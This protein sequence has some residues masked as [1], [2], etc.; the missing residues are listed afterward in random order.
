MPFLQGQKLLP[1]SSRIAD[2]EARIEREIE[3]GAE[4][5]FEFENESGGMDSTVFVFEFS[6]EEVYAPPH[7]FFFHIDGG[8]CQC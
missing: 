1:Q 4:F 7:P 2:C 8:R 6:Q 3:T 5:E